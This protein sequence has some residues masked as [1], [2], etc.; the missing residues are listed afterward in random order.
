MAQAWMVT[1]AGAL[2]RTLEVMEWV[3]PL[4]AQVSSAVMLP[5]W[6]TTVPLGVPQAAGGRTPA[7][8]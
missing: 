4:P 3:T 2:I 5:A 8:G 1:V 7:S 6:F